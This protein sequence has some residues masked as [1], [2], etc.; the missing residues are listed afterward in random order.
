MHISTLLTFHL[1]P[2]T[3]TLASPIN[4]SP[5]VLHQRTDNLLFSTPMILFQQT[6]HAL[7]PPPPFDWTDDG[8]SGPA[9]P[10]LFGKSCQRHDFGYRNYHAQGRCSDDDREHIDNNFMNDMSNE[11]QDALDGIENVALVPCLE[12]AGV[13]FA[14]VRGGGSSSFCDGK[15]DEEDLGF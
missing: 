4:T 2:I 6:K 15:E 7:P 11:C 14:A 5:L 9:P 1:I 8:C 10:G 13:Y 3:I 12:A